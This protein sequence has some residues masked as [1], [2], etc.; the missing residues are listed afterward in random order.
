MRATAIA[1]LD[2]PN[3]A[4]SCL[5]R[6]LAFDEIANLPAELHDD[7]LASLEVSDD[8]GARVRSSLAHD[9][10]APGLPRAGSVEPID[11]AD[12]M[13]AIEQSM[14]GT[15]VATFRL[16]ELIGQGGSSSVFRAE[17]QVGDGV[18][19]VALKLLRTGLYSTDAQR[20]FRREQTILACFIHPN[21]ARLIEGGVSSSGIP[22]IAMELVDGEPIT[23]AADSRSLTIDQ[24]LA[25]FSK[26]CRTIEAAHTALIVHRDIKPSNLFITAD[27]DL[28]VLD[29][30]I[31]K[32]IESD[33]S[34]THTQSISLTPEYAAPEQFGTAPLTTA[35]DVYALGVV[36]GELLT[37]KRL[38]SN[39]RASAAV[40][41]S[42]E[43]LPQGV[44]QRSTLIRRLRGDLDAIVATA[45]ADEPSMRY[46]SAGAFADDIDRYL[47][48]TP[49]RA[50]PPSRWYQLR[51]FVARHRVVV[52]ATMSFLLA[53]VIALGI[54]L[55]QARVAQQQVVVAREQ[56]QRAEAVRNFLVSVFDAA[57]ANL[58]K[59][60]RPSVEDIV[61]QATLRLNT[62]ATLPDATRGDLLLT[63]AKV[64]S[65]VGLSE[66]TIALLDSADVTIERLHGSGS[67]AWWDAK[68]LRASAIPDAQTIKLLDPLREQLLSRNDD[69]GVRG[70]QLLSGAL[71]VEGRVDEG[72]A[73]TRRTVAIAQ[74]QNTQMSET[75]LTTL[76]LQA[77]ELTSNTVG[78]FREGLECAD[79][80]LVLWEAR[81]KPPGT[82]IIG[83]YAAIGLGAEATG[84]IARAEKAYK[85]AIALSDRFFDRPNGTGAWNIGRYG[86]FLI[87][88][89]RLDEGQDY[90]LQGLKMRRLAFGDADIRTIDSLASMSQLSIARRDDTAALDWATQGTDTCRVHSLHAIVCARVF[91]VRAKIYAWQGRF[92]EAERDLQEALAEQGTFGGDA[93]PGY[94][95]IL[96]Y[97]LAVQIAKHDNERALAT[98]DRTLAI[99]QAAKGGSIQ[100]NLTTRF[101]RAQ[102][103]FELGQND[104]AVQEL[105]EV[106]PKYSNLFP[107][108]VYRFEMLALRSRAL[109]RAHRA[110]EASEAARQALAMENKSF[111]GDAPVI[112]EL[113]RLAATKP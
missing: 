76:I 89:G 32:L 14:V 22:Y 47:E 54:A 16:L 25:L 45:L 5:Q 90:V 85:E 64:A 63:L 110:F 78:R 50:Y 70:L 40:A 83:L 4:R 37:G 36:L 105:L 97:V 61:E 107:N 19:I 72:L 33:E 80:A 104:E 57:G 94:G 9:V 20:R 51:K 88:Q 44:P 11:H 10:L 35:V 108:G 49:V 112:D 6:M 79:E 12:E 52:V 34:S 98:A 91:G 96:G 56:T 1:A 93:T 92:V 18:Q 95:V 68:L 8:V 42:N 26:V 109:A 101:Y 29:F 69:V 73:L 82:A 59:E 38:N 74:A 3:E 23:T 2:L 102:A 62:D 66:R 86:T 87:T 65:S 77:L 84:D 28:K 21:V 17:R 13:N 106:E 41:S 113:K 75:L 48:G 15:H 100:E 99:Y 55:W 67:A 31:A 81:G 60:K 27:G 7:A 43:P 71:L 24:R 58:P 39:Q 111:N 53:I 46:S 30:G 103:L